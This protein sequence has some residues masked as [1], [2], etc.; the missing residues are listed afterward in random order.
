MLFFYLLCSC[1]GGVQRRSD[2]KT[3]ALCSRLPFFGSLTA[4]EHADNGRLQEVAKIS[5]R[6]TPTMVQCKKNHA[7]APTAARSTTAKTQ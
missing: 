2:Q 7:A 3:E 1:Y 4:E 6:R 5:D